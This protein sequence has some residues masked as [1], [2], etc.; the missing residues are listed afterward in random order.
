MHISS[1]SS[2]NLH[3][4]SFGPPNISYIIVNKTWFVDII[5]LYLKIPIHLFISWKKIKKKNFFLWKSESFLSSLLTCTKSWKWCQE[6]HNLDVH[7]TPINYPKWWLQN[8]AYLDQNLAFWQGM[9]RPILW[10]FCKKKEKI[11]NIKI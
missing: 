10:K 9:F 4:E 5:L 2:Y 1:D 3:F 6:F 11:Q 7:S 8:G